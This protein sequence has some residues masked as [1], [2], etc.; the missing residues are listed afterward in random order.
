MNSTNFDCGR[1]MTPFVGTEY[2]SVGLPPVVSKPWW[3]GNLAKGMTA[4]D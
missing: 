1:N 2:T 3:E 4:E